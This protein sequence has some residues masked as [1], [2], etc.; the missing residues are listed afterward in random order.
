MR[1]SGIPRKVGEEKNETLKNC[2]KKL[3]ENRN[4]ELKSQ[5]ETNQEKTTGKK[6]LKRSERNKS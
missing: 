6:D 2:V 4:G 1:I 3:L 5:R